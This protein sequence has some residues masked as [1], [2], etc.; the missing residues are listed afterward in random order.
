MD[1]GN[2]K[3]FIY[4]RISRLKIKWNRITKHDFK[5]V[6]FNKFFRSKSKPA[7]IF[8]ISINLSSTD[9]KLLLPPFNTLGNIRSKSPFDSKY[10]LIII[11]NVFH[12][13]QY[14]QKLI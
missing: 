13:Y 8:F 2:E 6:N 10:L 12:L 11:S 3:I 4:I 14:K 1:S 9:V 7:T 5:N